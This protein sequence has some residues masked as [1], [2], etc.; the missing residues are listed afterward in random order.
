MHLSSL[1]RNAFL[2]GNYQLAAELYSEA[3]SQQPELSHIYLISL[4]QSRKKLQ[5]PPISSSDLLDHISHYRQNLAKLDTSQTSS[6][7]SELELVFKKISQSTHHFIASETVTEPLVSVIVAVHNGSSSIESSITSLLR[8]SWKNLEIIVVDLASSD[9]TWT[10]LQ[11]LS[12]S[13]SNLKCYQLSTSQGLEFGINYAL[14][15]S[16]GEYFFFQGASDFSHP[17]RVKLCMQELARHDVAAVRTAY[18]ELKGTAI[19]QPQ[20]VSSTDKILT[21]GLKR[22]VLDQIGYL[23]LKAFADEEYLERLS[24]WTQR[25]RLSIIKIDLQ[26]YYRSTPLDHS[27]ISYRTFAS[28]DSESSIKHIKDYQSLHKS[29]GIDDFR[30]AFSFPPTRNLPAPFSELNS[31]S[32]FEFPVIANICS[33]P[34]REGLLK[35]ALESFSSQV[36]EINLYLDR[37]SEIPNFVKKCH[38]NIKVHLSKDHPGLRDNGKFLS[39]SPTISDC[40]YFTMDD[41]IV[42]PP[43][44]IEHMVQGIESYSRRAVVG[45]HGVLLPEYPEGYFTSFRKVHSFNYG[46][47]TNVLVNNLGT[48]TVAFHSSVMRGLNLSHFKKPGM[49][50]LYLSVFCK[51]QHIPMIALSRP[52]GW[53]REL[54]SPNTSLYHEFKAVDVDQSNLVRSYTPWGYSSI[55]HVIHAMDTHDNDPELRSKL[56]RMIPRLWQCLI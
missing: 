4:N 44:Y 55:K 22:A 6:D 43:D 1:A 17:D 5:L 9:S 15:R 29:L 16:S 25:S 20:F 23:L 51:C 32:N 18:L 56:L 19:N 49:A 2:T 42:Y 30:Y 31:K 48:G 45:L 35:Q 11:R 46:L 12:R 52:D 36:D 10:I 27:S 38:P 13:V 8:Q 41:D 14:K 24:A 40:Y 47:E 28:A 50:D 21:L 33:I 54:P 34:E 53:L 26:L 3:I 39:F 7:I 37:Y